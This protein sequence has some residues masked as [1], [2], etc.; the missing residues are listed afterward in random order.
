MTHRGSILK[1][2]LNVAFATFLSRILGLFRVMFE[3]MVLGGGTVASAWQLAFM[4]P[5]SFRRIL[6][7]GALGTALIPVLVQTEER[8][9]REKVRA[10]LSVVFAVLGILLAAIV[11]ACSLGAIWLVPH[12]E[13][14]YWKLALK[15]LPLLMP[16]AL[17]ICFSGVVG[18]V[19]NSRKE[20]FLP[21]LGAVLLNVFL[22]PVWPPGS[23][24]ATSTNLRSFCGSSTCWR[25][26]C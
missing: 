21:A 11:I 14:E 17:L 7:E 9:G 20:F 22:I 19:L 12:V 8:E 15:I 23:F 25:I 18:A 10:D 1:Q 2:S 5:N 26:S 3:S 6:G 16:Y 24:S 13:A 4:I